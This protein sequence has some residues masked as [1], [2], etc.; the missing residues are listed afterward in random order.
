MSACCVYGCRY[1]DGAVCARDGVKIYLLEGDP[2][3]F[4]CESCIGYVG[5]GNLPLRPHCD[6]A[7]QAGSQD[8]LLL[9][10]L[11]RIEKVGFDEMAVML[12]KTTNYYTYDSKGRQTGINS[13]WPPE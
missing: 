5:V 10:P 4:V 12:R 7:N 3:A 13:K 2:S 6:W 8:P 9:S 1:E 11:G